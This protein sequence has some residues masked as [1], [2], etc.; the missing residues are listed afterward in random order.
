MTSDPMPEPDGQQD[1]RF[2]YA[3]TAAGVEAV[4]QGAAAFDSERVTP[5]DA[6]RNALDSTRSG[7]HD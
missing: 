3:L 1:E 7:A 6:D 2:V 4:R 5:G